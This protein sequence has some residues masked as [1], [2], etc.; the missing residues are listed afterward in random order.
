MNE[1]SPL[2]QLLRE[3][4][5]EALSSIDL[6][7]LVFDALAPEAPARGRVVLIAAGKAAPKMAEGALDRWG[8]RID[9]ALV[10]TTSGTDASFLEGRAETLR[11]AHPIPD[12][13]SRLAAERALSIV[14]RGPD[15]LLLALISG[16][17]SSLLQAPPQGMSFSEFQELAS[18]LVRSSLPISRINTVRRHLSRLQGGRLALAASPA[19]TLT[20]YASDIPGGL[21]YE[22]GSG[23]TLPSPAAL[24]DARRA[25]EEALGPGEASKY[26]PFLESPLDP[27]S[28]EASR[29]EALAV[30]TPTLLAERVAEKLRSAGFRVSMVGERIA[31][32]EELV[33]EYGELARGLPKGSAI[34]APCEPVLS[35]PAAAGEGGR[36][37]HLALAL[38]PKLPRDVAFLAGAS[39]GVDGSSSLAG[40]CVSGAMAFEI[41]AVEAALATF[42]DAPMHRS[43]GSSLQTGPTGINLTDVHILARA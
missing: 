28:E 14:P 24:E 27:S 29:T 38:L 18:A 17:A 41:A 42:D 11:A 13:T 31:S 9:E 3:T 34:V 40:A 30:A 32:L 36:A 33:A 4:F 1:P 26:L 7:R 43:L 8:A 20:L 35:V 21:A 12:E 5:I 6:R 37:G 25:L 39:D 23:P 10:V 16:G 22:V 19:R 15:D 2:C